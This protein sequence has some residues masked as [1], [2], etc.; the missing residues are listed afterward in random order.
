MQ[1]S[2]EAYPSVG[3]YV[4]GRY[5]IDALLGEGGMGAV[6]LATD[7]QGSRFALKFPAPDIRSR[8]GMMSRFANEALAASRIASEHVVK[9]F[10]VEATETGVPFI[11]MEL[12]EG[13][14][15]DAIIDREAP[16]DI[17]RAVHFAL[18]IL[19]ALQV[20]HAAGVVHRD[21]KPS[22]CFVITQ[23]GEPDFVKLIDF[24]I[25]KILG[26]DG[27]NQTR[28]SVT[29]GTPAY[30]SPEQA[31]SAKAAEPRSDL[32]SVGVIL[33]ELLTK[34]RPFEGE[35]GNELVVKIC[36]EPPLPI[37]Q[38]RPD[39][40]PRLASAVEHALVKIPAG[41]YEGA[42]AFAHA[43]APFADARSVDVLQRIDAGITNNAPLAAAL[44]PTPPVGSPPQRAA[45]GGTAMMEP[46]AFGDASATPPPVEG[47]APQRTV[48]ADGP[49][50]FADS[51]PAAAP[52]PM[53]PPPV[54]SPPPAMVPAPP[55]EYQS[56]RRGGGGGNGALFAVLGVVALGLVGT[57]IYFAMGSSSGPSTAPTTSKTS[58]PSEPEEEEDT[59][60]GKKKKK[61]APADEPTTAPTPD[62]TVAAPTPAAPATTT[63]T[64]KTTPSTSTTTSPSTTTA[65]STTASTKPS[66]T[67]T[68]P[69]IVLPPGWPFPGGTS[70][71]PP[72]ATTTPPP[73]TTTP[74]PATTTP[75]P[76]T[77]TAPPVVVP[78]FKPK[79]G[80]K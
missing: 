10:G 37:R 54:A 15:L 7:A 71:T 25:T 24:G 27:A 6:F 65:P 67:T 13:T 33:Y 50:A 41:R 16:V 18:Q 61:K 45:A 62:E 75:P 80:G 12:L 69:T 73:A 4:G 3:S 63:K 2:M 77:T 52:A 64:V 51:A 36:T 20:S 38:V 48:V 8:P 26:D 11:V 68:A 57:G 34:K 30:M 21:M 9:I 5:R 66:G 44:A 58:S 76:A 43:L 40:P 49:M 60:E 53:M 46:M 1:R 35:S 29:M 56:S 22:N 74:P 70:T 31:R 39:L 59:P 47:R 23:A 17:P 28:T 42:Q 78:P 79:I 19:R 55:G 14:D 32:Y 72:P